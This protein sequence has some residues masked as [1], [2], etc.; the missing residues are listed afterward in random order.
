MS[1]HDPFHAIY[2]DYRAALTI[3]LTRGDRVSKAV[4]LEREDQLDAAWD[5][6]S[7]TVPPLTDVGQLCFT[8]KRIH[9][10]LHAVGRQ[11]VWPEEGED[12]E[13]DA[14]AL[15]CTAGGYLE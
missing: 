6:L 15:A 11:A 10:F 12:M 13:D 2:D 9:F 7:R 3:A 1:V 8:R 4:A 14:L 5:R